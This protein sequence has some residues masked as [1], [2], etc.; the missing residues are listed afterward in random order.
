MTKAF[1]RFQRKERID[2]ETLCEA[3]SRAELGLIDADLGSGLIKQRVARVGQ[4]RS[5]GHRTI[6]AYRTAARSVFL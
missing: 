6:I 2:D 3:I 5:G 4:G 1:R